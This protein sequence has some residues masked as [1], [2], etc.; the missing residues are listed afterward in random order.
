MHVPHRVL[1]RDGE[2]VI[3]LLLPQRAVSLLRPT[4]PANLDS[5]KRLNLEF[6]LKKNPLLRV[7]GERICQLSLGDR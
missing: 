4:H 2:W 6:F 1:Y 5:E 3:T 7:N